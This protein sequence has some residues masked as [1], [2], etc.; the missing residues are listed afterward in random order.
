MVGVNH[1]MHYWT[2]ATLFCEYSYHSLTVGKVG[3]AHRQK[4]NKKRMT[5][6]VR[7]WYIHLKHTHQVTGDAGTCFDLVMIPYNR[8]TFKLRAKSPTAPSRL[9]FLLPFAT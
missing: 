6:G 7:V 4:D 2:A 9:L 1:P 5:T 3:M 8:F